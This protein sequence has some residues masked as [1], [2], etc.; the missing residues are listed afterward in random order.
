MSNHDELRSQGVAEIAEDAASGSVAALYADIRSSLGTDLVNLIYR[1]LATVPGALE[2]AWANLAPHFRSGEFDAHAGVLRERVRG[3]AKAWAARFDFLSTP[4]AE[5]RAAAN[6]VG[7]YN[8]N[9]SRNLLAFRHLLEGGQGTPMVNPGPRRMP[10]ALGG[11]RGLP[12]IPPWAT[13]NAIDRATVL[14]L[15]G[16]GEPGEPLI[17]ASLYRHLALWPSLLHNVEAALSRLDARGDI[18]RALT[19]T[20]EESRSLVCAHPLPM[21]VPP[22]PTVDAALRSR[23]RAFVD[24]TIP[25]MVPV[26]M[27][28]EAALITFPSAAPGEIPCT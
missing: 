21:P 24:L 16:L 25:K 2:W 19:F 9:N 3:F 6:L 5:R 26:G 1:H 22:P 11:E 18:T 10:W 14:R 13:M 28:L 23:L 7:T 8:H 20:V 15:N 4:V 17:V 27:A 12:A